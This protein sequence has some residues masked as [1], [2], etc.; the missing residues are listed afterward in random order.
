MGVD[1]QSKPEF[2]IICLDDDRNFLN[3]LKMSIYSKLTGDESYQYN[4][5]FMNNPIKTLKLIDDLS[6][7]KEEIALLIADQMMP[8]MK[9]IDFLKKTKAVT[10]ETMRVLLTGYAGMDSA[11]SAINDHILDKYLTKPIEDIDDLVITLKLLLTEFQLKRKVEMQHQLITDLY[12][13]SNSLNSQDNISE[14][15]EHIISFA[16]HVMDCSR[17]SVLLQEE[18][19]LVLKAATGISEDIKKNIRIPIGRG[20][21]GKVFRQK[22]AI[23]VKDIKQIS[24]LKEPINPKSKSFISF[25]LIYAGLN[26]ANKSLGVIN[27]TNKTDDQ[28]FS[29][30][31][32]MALTFIANTASIAIN[33]QYN[34]ILLEE[35]YFNIASSLII[36]LES[37]DPYTKGHSLRVMEYSV[38]IAESF[39]MEPEQIELLKKA[40]ILHDIGKIGISDGLLLKPDKLTLDEYAQIKKH[41]KIGSAIISPI[42]FLKGAEIIVRH[43]HERYDGGGYPDGLKAEKIPLEAR[44]MAVADSYDAMTSSRPYR[45]ALGHDVAV[46]ELENNAGSQFDPKCVEVFLNYLKSDNKLRKKS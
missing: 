14:T 35:A 27:V 5:F 40:A 29:E 45:E 12:E 15:L 28:A 9:G 2:H 18:G 42:S 1:L 8:E 31:D 30:H 10:P 41:S 38:V 6:R 3:S 24:W 46:S 21:S 44:I 23:L 25:P 16:G 20:V 39:Q 11:V 37:R 36:A 34:R 19:Q 32:L 33:N 26:S 22:D 7:S 17:I 4:M 13:F 43:H